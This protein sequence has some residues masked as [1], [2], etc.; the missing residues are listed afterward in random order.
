MCGRVNIDSPLTRDRGRN[1]YSRRLDALTSPR[2]ALYVS[3]YLCTL[4]VYTYTR[5]EYSNLISQARP[6]SKLQVPIEISLRFSRT[7]HILLTLL[8]DF[9]FAR[10]LSLY[11]FFINILQQINIVRSYRTFFCALLLM[12]RDIHRKSCVTNT[13]LSLSETGRRSNFHSTT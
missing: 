8:I 2:K 9:L 6:P 13:I 5:W 7:F 3:M 1:W 10:L 12:F 4:S 11:F